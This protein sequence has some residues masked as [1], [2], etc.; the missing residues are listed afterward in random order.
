MMIDGHADQDQDQVFATNSV[1]AEC[2]AIVLG[3]WEEEDKGVERGVKVSGEWIECGYVDMDGRGVV[4]GL[5]SASDV[6]L[7]ADG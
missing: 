4:L 2:N 6:V 7:M 5:G 3:R 1:K